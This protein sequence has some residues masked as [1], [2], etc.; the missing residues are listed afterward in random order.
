MEVFDKSGREKGYVSSS[1]VTILAWRFHQ[2]H[3]QV[4]LKSFSSTRVCFIFSYGRIFG[5]AISAS[6]FSFEGR[7]LYIQGAFSLT[8]GGGGLYEGSHTSSCCVA[9]TPNGYSGTKG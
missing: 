8:L 2:C 7:R 3:L 4:V 1:I 9:H 6:R 5:L